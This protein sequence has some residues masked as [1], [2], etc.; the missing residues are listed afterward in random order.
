MPSAIVRFGPALYLFAGRHAHTPR[1]AASLQNAL[2]R[3]YSSETRS[4]MRT[5]SA[6]AMILRVCT[7]TLLSPRSIS[8]MCAR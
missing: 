7:V 5:P 6:S 1:G 4:R 2:N 3:S 8:P